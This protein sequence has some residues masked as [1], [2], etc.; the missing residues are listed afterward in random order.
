MF[1]I[2]IK[3]SA[4]HAR[5]RSRLV[6]LDAEYEGSVYHV[7]TYYDHPCRSFKE[8]DEAFRVRRERTRTTGSDPHGLGETPHGASITLTYKGPRVDAYSKTRQEIETTLESESAITEILENLG[9]TSLPPVK[10]TREHYSYQGFS[11]TLDSVD[12]LGSF[13]EIETQGQKED[14]DPLRN[15]ARSLL[16]DL[17]GD[18]TDTIPTSYLSLLLDE[19]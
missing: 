13:V 5:L 3:A 6:D 2:E 16:R 9:F 17:G 7:D 19:K 10:K 4:D 15:Q 1:E 12:Q 11:I 18:P 14:I 8:T